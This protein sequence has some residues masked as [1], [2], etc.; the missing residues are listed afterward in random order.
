[1]STR[2]IT[3]I[4]IVL[5]FALAGFAAG[6]ATGGTKVSYHRQIK[7]ILQKR[8][9]GCHQ[10][11]TQGGKLI[12]TTFE[13]FRAGGAAG[14][15]FKPGE[16]DNSVVLKFISGDPPAM[17]KNAKPLSKAEVDLFRRW[18]LEGAK[19]DTPV[20]KDPI[21]PA[22]PPTYRA[23][24]VVSAIAFSPDGSTIAV[25]GYREVLLHKADGSAIAARLVGKS[26]RIESIVYSPD[27]KYLAI[28][29]GAPAKF[30]EAQF[31]DTVTNRLVNAA[32]LSYDVLYGASF[33]PDSKQLAVGAAD[34][35]ARIISVPDGKVLFKFDNHSDW[36]FATGW[37]MPDVKFIGTE[38][39]KYKGNTNRPLLPEETMHLLTTGRDRAI[40]LLMAKNG[41]FVDDIN[42]HTSPYRTLALRPNSMQVLVGGDDGIPRLYQIYRTKPRT[43][44][45]EDQSLIRTY[46]QQPGQI[47]AVAFN[48]DGS[49]FAVG[50]ESGEIRIY[51]TEDGKRLQTLKAGSGPVYALTYRKDGKQIAAGGFDGTVRVFDADSGSMAA[52]F[53]GVPLT[54][55]SARN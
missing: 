11:A 55:K 42:T 21:N 52:S 35:S 45:Q 37:T 5:S 12:L 53:I 24:P 48:L 19:N 18:I 28:V 49:K 1:M 17:P 14:P 51:A 39:E 4:L 8:C 7:P 43:M 38:V 22:N 47:N 33:S 15:G 32:E 13:A 36:V 25:S 9:Q 2:S 29:G 54:L 44:N 23:A 16:P 20:V 50:T 46:E 26:P 40:K 27:G 30:G 41:S 34:N 6:Q 10:A 31:W 3:A